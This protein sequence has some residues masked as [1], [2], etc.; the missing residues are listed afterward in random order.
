MAIP[1]TA[2]PF[3]MPLDPRDRNKFYVFVNQGAPDATPTPVLRLG[4]GSARSSLPLSG[5]AVAVGLESLTDAARAPRLDGNQLIIWHDV[6]DGMRAN[7]A[8][9]GGGVTV[10]VLVQVVTTSDPARTEDHSYLVRIAN[11]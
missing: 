3:P 4:E 5:E 7:S 8:F 1:A 11:A 6:A 10:P 9:A 2:K